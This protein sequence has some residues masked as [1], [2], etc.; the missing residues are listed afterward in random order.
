VP[1]SNGTRKLKNKPGTGI[2]TPRLFNQYARSKITNKGHILG[3]DNRGTWP[4]RLRDVIALFCADCGGASV[5]SEAKLA[6]IKRAAVLVVELE[7]RELRFAEHGATDLQLEQ[8]SRVA[9]NLR[10]MLE[11]IQPGLERVPKD[12]TPT[13][14]EYI[15][16][17]EAAE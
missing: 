9:A 2:A 17:K 15:E 1:I 6:V 3:L 10:R 5:L 7:Q 16:A 11:S 12:I 13:L 8:Y 14:R 4:R